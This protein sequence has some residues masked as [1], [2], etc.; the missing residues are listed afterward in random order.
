MAKT[1][2][3]KFG[4]DMFKELYARYATDTLE[5]FKQWVCNA[6]QNNMTSSNL[7]KSEFV[8][9]IQACTSKDRVVRKASDM[10]MARDFKVI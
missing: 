8:R 9:A 10:F 6:I 4:D 1:T 7:K 2:V 3:D 5:A